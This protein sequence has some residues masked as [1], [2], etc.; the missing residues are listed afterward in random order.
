MKLDFKIIPHEEQAYPTVGNYYLS[1]GVWRF[2]VSWMKDKRY[3]W[4]VLMHEF[5]EWGICQLTGV[6]GKAIDRF[7]VAYEKRRR[8][9]EVNAHCGCRIK[10]EPG[11]DIHAPYHDAHGVASECERLIAKCLGV[12]W[13]KYDE[14]VG[15]L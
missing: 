15:K 3:C 9:G 1:K 12:D 2:R 7:D 4:L 6:K 8:A 10:D 11:D 5:I 14:T 13:V